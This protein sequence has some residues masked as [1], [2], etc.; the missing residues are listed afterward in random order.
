[1]KIIRTASGKRTIK[2]SKSEWESIGEKHGWMREAITPVPAPSLMDAGKPGEALLDAMPSK[3]A[4]MLRTELIGSG[5]SKQKA[6]PFIQN[7]LGGFDSVPISQVKNLIEEMGE[8]GVLEDEIEK[9]DNLGTEEQSETLAEDLANGP[10]HPT[11][12]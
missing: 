1:M 7:L 3:I 4:L 8:E 11:K 10:A 12:L 9:I 5:I 2:I 6:L